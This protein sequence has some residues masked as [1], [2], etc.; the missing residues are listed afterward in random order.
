MSLETDGTVKLIEPYGG[1]LV[2]LLAAAEEREELLS[3]ASQLPRL[4]LTPRNL[5]DL[6]LLATG[7]FSPLDRFMGGDD[8]RRVLAEMRLTSGALFPLPVTLTVSRDAKLTPG[9]EIA[10]ADQSN[11]LL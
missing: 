4:Q 8:Y 10:L 1:R 5:C 9:R 11:N 2:S 7:G 6:E 3:L